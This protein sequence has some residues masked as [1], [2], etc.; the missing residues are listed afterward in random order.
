MGE[1]METKALYRGGAGREHAVSRDACTDVL[2]NVSITAEHGFIELLSPRVARSK[3][4]TQR[5]F[6]NN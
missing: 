1:G 5:S 4:P 6:D 3:K 2:I